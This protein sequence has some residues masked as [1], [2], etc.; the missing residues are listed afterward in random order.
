ME[1]RHKI[2]FN[3]I[4]K[5]DW[6]LF[7]ILLFLCI[8][9]KG[10]VIFQGYAVDDYVTTEGVGELQQLFF[11]QGRFAGWLI[12]HLL[13]LFGVNP[14]GITPITGF[15]ALAMQ[16]A[17]AVSAIRFI[18]YSSLLSA[19]IAGSIMVLH[20][21]SAEI[22]T[23][24]MVLPNYCFSMLFA[25][26]AIESI[27]PF[28]NTST[29]RSISLSIV[30][31]AISVI[32]Y[33]ISLNYLI[34]I[35]AVG[36]LVSFCF[37]GKD[38]QNTINLRKSSFILICISFLAGVINY[39]A[40]AFAKILKIV[41][42][43]SDNRSS[44]VSPSDILIRAGEAMETL[45][46]IYLHG[47]PVVP[48]FLAV[49]TF[50]ILSIAALII[51]HRLLY[52]RNLKL[53]ISLGVAAGLAIPI[54][55]VG[56]II[57]LKS[58]WPAPRVLSQYSYIVGLLG[59]ASLDHCS[60]KLSRFNYKMLLAL[61]SSV[62]LGYILI[63]NQIFADQKNLNAWDAQLAN[64]LLTRIE[65]LP[66]GEKVKYIKI[67]GGHWAYPKNLKTTHMD[68]NISAFYPGYSKDKV[69]NIALGTRMQ[70]IEEHEART[71]KEICKD[72][73]KWPKPGSIKILKKTAFVCLPN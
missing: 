73:P 69:I 38:T 62:L 46:V 14:Q 47:S 66:N 64:R 15:S 6:L 30:F 17:L 31:A 3:S 1:A 41:T 59:L 29:I 5:H 23:F 42:V 48:K 49:A 58:W 26:F 7:G 71:S 35:G 60:L 11:S 70:L 61:V 8:L 27:Q 2:K 52:V 33:Q 24:R 20:P 44:I 21:F 56:V 57:I 67:N 22:L 51:V 50:V 25:L 16:A 68:M 4:S 39:L 9:S 13:D 43:V 53:A 36:L 37:D 10:A 40:L 63:N 54:L 45:K 32:F 28:R 19:V 34:V 18:G 65:S 72:Q 12:L 55:T